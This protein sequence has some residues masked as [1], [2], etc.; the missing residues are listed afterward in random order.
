MFCQKA[1]MS[2]LYRRDQL[3]TE[4][5]WIRL[6]SSSRKRRCMS[7]RATGGSVEHR[8]LGVAGEK[9]IDE[10]GGRMRV[11]GIFREPDAARVFDEQ[12]IGVA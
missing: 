8:S 9:E 2:S 11:R 4:I 3:S 7:L 5:T 10:Q 12:R 1:P 6:G